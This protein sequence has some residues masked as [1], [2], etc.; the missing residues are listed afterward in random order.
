MPWQG[1]ELW[2]AA[3]DGDGLPATPRRVAGGA[4]ESICQPRVVARRRAALRL[5]PQRLVEP[6]PPR[7]LG[8][9]EPSCPMDAEF[10]AAA[11]GL[12]P[13]DVRLRRPTPA[14]SACSTAMAARTWRGSMRTAS[15]RRAGDAVLH[16]IG[17]LRVGDGFVACMAGLR[18]PPSRRSS[19]ST[20]RA[21]RGARAAPLAATIALDAGDLS[22][23]ETISFASAGGAARARLLLPAAQPAVHRRRPAS[24]RR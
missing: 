11:L 5:R 1:T 6:V 23:A 13:V 17:E 4:D 22:V 12:R 24:G 18:R 3:L 2:V 10:G 8:G 9:V 7:A 15:L 19:A 21:A 16:D 20:S 14:S